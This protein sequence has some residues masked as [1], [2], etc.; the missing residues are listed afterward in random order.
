MED[1]KKTK[2]QFINELV[3]L[4]QR[5]AE[6]KVLELGNKRERA[7][8]EKKI[9]L[10]VAGMFVLLCIAVWLNEILDLPFLL[11]GPPQTPFNWH[12]SIIEMVLIAGTG[13]FVVSRL[14]RGAAWRKQAEEAL[15]K[16]EARYRHIVED[17]TEMI[18]RFLPGGILTFVNDAYCRCCGKKREELI[19][20]SFMSLI[21][22]EDHAVVEK[23]LALL[24]Q[25]NPVAASEHRVILPDGKIG[26]QQWSDR[27]IFNNKGKFTEFQSVGRDIT[28]RKRMEEALQKSHLILEQQVK[29]RTA[30]L[31]IKNEQLMK[32]IE[33]RRQAEM[34]LQESENKYRTVFETTGTATVIIEEDMIISLA[35]REFEKL[36]GYSR[37]ELEDKKTWTEFV[38]EDDVKQMK[39]YH[40]LRRLDSNA[41]PRNY[42]F[43]FIDR[44]GNVKDIFLTVAMI[45]GTKKNVAS[46]LDITEH[47][48]IDK[49]LQESEKKYRLIA[50]NVSD[51]IWTMDTSLKFTYTSP[52]VKSLRG[53]SVEEATNQTLE[54]I[55]APAS[56]KVAMEAF[57]RAAARRLSENSRGSMKKQCIYEQNPLKN[58]RRKTI[59]ILTTL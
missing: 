29:E 33:E 38:A 40:R 22:E 9:W 28:E 6:K 2:D 32:E 37:E 24:T 53:Y 34:M 23:N 52:S 11:L 59:F 27:M 58:Y 31:L 21:P 15:R 42:E 56:F 39:E 14:I 35:N 48:R 25:N 4:H 7:I 5:F 36:S 13:F 3:E 20:R 45:S 18:C 19:G 17:Q 41:A 12:E 8:L 26:W 51:V 16:S 54:E 47:K 44:D 57:E 10:P 30:E 55:L 50:D 49:A 46:F 1:E 43:A